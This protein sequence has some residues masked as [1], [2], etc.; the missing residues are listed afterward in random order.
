MWEFATLTS[1]G[2][3]AWYEAEL[4]ARFESVGPLPEEISAVAS[5]CGVD[6]ANLDRA[7]Q[8][9]IAITCGGLFGRIDSSWSLRDLQIVGEFTS[10]DGV[11]LVEPD[12]FAGSLWVDGD[13][14]RPPGAMVD[15]WRLST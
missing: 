11:P 13:W 15:Q 3:D 14:G 8:S 7:L 9:L 10:R 5:S 12:G 4:L 2:F 6:V 1:A